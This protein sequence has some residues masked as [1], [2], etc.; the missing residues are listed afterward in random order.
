MTSNAERSI[1]IPE[2]QFPGMSQKVSFT[3]K[4]RELTFFV[5]LYHSYKYSLFPLSL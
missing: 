2:L 1:K 4:A 3:S 5:K